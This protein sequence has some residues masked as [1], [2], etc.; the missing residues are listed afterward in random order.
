MERSRPKSLRRPFFSPISGL[1][2]EPDGITRFMKPPRSR[3][4]TLWFLAT[5]VLLWRITAQLV[6]D[7]GPQGWLRLSL[8]VMG[9]VFVACGLQFERIDMAPR[10]MDFD[11]WMN[12]AH[13]APADAARARG[14]LEAVARGER[15][16]PRA[17]RAG[18]ALRF[19]FDFQIVRG[20]KP[21]E[22]A[23][24]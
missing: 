23:R 13:P 24:A 15:S 17:W 8:T 9:L 7:D 1:S 3:N 10:E 20:T 16:G 6:P 19:V 18:K 12:R 4:A 22:R 14:I 5:I 11:E 21:L 2:G